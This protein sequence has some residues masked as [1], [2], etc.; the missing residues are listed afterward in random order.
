MS[1]KALKAIRLKNFKRFDSFTVGLSSANILVGPNNA[2]KSSII[3]SLRILYGARRYAIR[4]RPRIIN[5]DEGDQYGYE[6]PES[7]I[8]IELN[9]LSHNYNDET[10]EIEFLHENGHKLKIQ[11]GSQHEPRLF[12][13]GSGTSK[14]TGKS[15]FDRFPIDI[16]IVPTLSPF[17]SSEPYISDEVVERQRSTRLSSRHFRNIWYREK[18]QF[19]DFKSLIEQTWPGV[20]IEEPKRPSIVNSHMEMFFYEGRLAREIAWSGFGL[21]VWMQII[22]HMMRGD[23][24]SI[25]VLDE[26]DV[27]LHPDMQRKLLG[28][29]EKR[30]KQYILATHSTEII[31]ESD[32]GD[33]L[34]IDSNRSS[35]RRIRTDKDYN[36]V[37]AYIGS[38]DNIEM[39]K[40]TRAKRVVF[41]EGKDKKIL[42][43]F[44]RKIGMNSPLGSS[45][46][47][48]IEV[49]GFGQ[50]TRVLDTA[51]T[52]KNILQIEVGIFALFDRDY[53]DEREI[54]SI[55]T[56]IASKGVQCAIWGRKEIENYALELKSLSRCIIERCKERGHSIS[57]IQA[58]QIIDNVSD[59]YKHDVHSNMAS[60]MFKYE[61]KLKSGMDFSQAIKISSINIDS[62]WRD[63][64]KRLNIISGKNFIAD[65]SRELQRN[66][67]TTITQSMLVDS[68]KRDEIDPELE[69]LLKKLANF[70]AA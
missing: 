36:D 27:Y 57:E 39:A 49:G 48:V 5:T 23:E 63:M 34:T 32:H 64:Q 65:L 35:A 46:T 2:G 14:Y 4:L 15:Y 59:Q 44:G 52:F 67:D 33:I 58:L 43:R 28:L 51:W 68:L 62:S 12:I 30:F 55:L 26:P 38:I 29:V 13:S 42:N 3:D 22:T 60:N 50:W 9:H 56:D 25:F 24:H 54:K 10:I 19:S 21:Q 20:T 1:E 31:N 17:E 11:F 53:R 41:F 61:Q 47:V 18:E 8:P 45:D 16:V 69:D 7:S 37:Y 70:C 66:F 6:I 40:L